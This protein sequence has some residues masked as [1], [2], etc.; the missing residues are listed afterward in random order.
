M[1]VITPGNLWESQ[2][3][4]ETLIL[5]HPFHLSP[6][7]EQ[8]HTPSSVDLCIGSQTQTIVR[9]GTI[10]QHWRQTCLERCKKYQDESVLSLSLSVSLPFHI[11]L[12]AVR[13]KC[14]SQ[15]A[16]N[17]VNPDIRSGNFLYQHLLCP[18]DEGQA[19]SPAWQAGARSGT[20]ISLRIR[21]CVAW[22]SQ[23]YCK[24]KT[25]K[26]PW[27][28]SSFLL[29]TLSLPLSQLQTLYLNQLLDLSSFLSS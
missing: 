12:P 2:P 10:F 27:R 25:L 28:F 1:R 20:K 9:H 3:R 18:W 15:E 5:A 19:L 14:C 16:C 17:W 23:V 21:G 29:N 11:L 6:S 13:D 24:A 7:I 22:S 4:P 8:S 26:I